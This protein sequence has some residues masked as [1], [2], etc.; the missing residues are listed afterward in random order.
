[1]HERIEENFRVRND[2]Y[3]HMDWLTH[4]PDLN[5]IKEAWNMLGKALMKVEPQP[6]KLQIQWPQISQQAIKNLSDRCVFS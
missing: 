5:P 3:T 2:V 1:M 6:R 4:S